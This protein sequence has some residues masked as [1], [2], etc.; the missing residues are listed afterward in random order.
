MSLFLPTI[1]TASP[2]P[3][4]RR[5]AAASLALAAILA[6]VLAVAAPARAQNG[7]QSLAAPAA[8]AGGVRSADPGMA[9]AEKA[10]SQKRYDEAIDRFDRVL[11][12]NP[13]NAQ[14]R[15]ERAWALAQA[16]RED[17]AIAALASMAQDFPEL[18]EPHNNLALLYAKRGDL[19]RAEAEL[20]IAI[21]VKPDFAVGYAN[22]GDVYRRL[23]ENAY[24]DALRHNPKEAG[25][26]AGLRQLQ[27]AVASQPA[28]AARKPAA[29]ASAPAAA[30]A[31]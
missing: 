2:Q 25:A 31:R 16:G 3:A 28:G 6:G 1:A 24:R 26:A 23:A 5:I 17:E 8:A 22:L 15:F 7:P 9:D 12:T 30:P 14:A 29:A 11:A 18:P 27:P 19:K 4:H 21:D 20:L 13:R 10:A